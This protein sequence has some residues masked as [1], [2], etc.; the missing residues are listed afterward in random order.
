MRGNIE[1]KSELNKGTTFTMT[2]PVNGEYNDRNENSTKAEKL[3][4]VEEG[5]P[6]SINSINRKFMHPALR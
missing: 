3:L 5:S 4:R 6:R 2:I 1:V